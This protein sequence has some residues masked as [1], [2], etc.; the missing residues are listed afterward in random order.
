MERL[1]EGVG[2]QPT[3][4]RVDAEHPG[5]N[6][7]QSSTLPPLQINKKRSTP[8]WVL[9]SDLRLS[10]HGALITELRGLR[11]PSR[12]GVTLPRRSPT[13]WRI[14]SLNVLRVNGVQIPMAYVRD[15]QRTVRLS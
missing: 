8:G 9:T 12:V 15:W 13:L 1:A 10:R 6:R 11:H 5:R 7:M 3:A 14:L 2:F 4:R